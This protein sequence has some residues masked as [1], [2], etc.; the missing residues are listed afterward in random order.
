MVIKSY[1]FY[2]Q[3]KAEGIAFKEEKSSAIVIGT[4]PGFH[5]G[6]LIIFGTEKDGDDSSNVQRICKI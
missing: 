6:V 5:N 4:N 2:P 1:G 3:M